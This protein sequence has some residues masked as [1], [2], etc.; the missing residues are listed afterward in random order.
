MLGNRARRVFLSF[1][2]AFG[3]LSKK[4]VFCRT[5]IRGIKIRKAEFLLK[6]CSNPPLRAKKRVFLDKINEKL[7]D[8]MQFS[9]SNKFFT[10]KVKPVEK[11]V[12]TV[13]NSKNQAFSRVCSKSPLWK[14]FAEIL[15]S[16]NMQKSVF[17]LYAQK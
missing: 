12:E 8:F 1:P 11:L 17:L 16:G 14:T 5:R 9:H 3:G 15:S 7:K 6:K 4:I 10:R 13:E 2:Q